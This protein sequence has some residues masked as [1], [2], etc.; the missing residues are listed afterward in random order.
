[1]KNKEKLNWLPKWKVT[2][3]NKGEST[4]YEVNEFDGNLLTNEGMNHLWK[5]ICGDAV[6]DLETAPVL[7]VGTGSGAATT[8]DDENTFTA[9]V[10]EGMEAG[11][12]TFGTD[13]KANWKA[14]YDGDTANQSWQEFGLL[15]KTTD[16][17]L[18]NRKVSDQGTKVSGQTW[19]LELEIT[20]S[21]PD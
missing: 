19:E 18:I 14:S 7:I 21:N 4:P 10:K 20:L 5:I 6:D 2:K 16:G 15:T 3:Y 11:Y 8:S 12:P 9:G 13:Q 1:M 17:V